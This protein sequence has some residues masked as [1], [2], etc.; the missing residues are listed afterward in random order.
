MVLGYANG[1]I[2]YIPTQPAYAQG[3]Y[4][5]EDAYKYYGYP[6]ALAPQAGDLVLQGA[7]RSL[8]RMALTLPSPKGRG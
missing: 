3:G 6:A 7:V 8:A 5:V 1:D 4:E 2:G